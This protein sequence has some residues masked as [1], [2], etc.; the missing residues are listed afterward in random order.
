MHN[1]ISLQYPKRKNR[2]GRRNTFFLGTVL[3]LL[4][5]DQSAVVSY[6]TLIKKALSTLSRTVVKILSNSRNLNTRGNRMRYCA[7]T[8][9]GEGSRLKWRYE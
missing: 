7:K 1:C 2:P 4:N 9:Y 3:I 5:S 6:L 8:S